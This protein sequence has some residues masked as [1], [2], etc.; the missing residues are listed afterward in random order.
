MPRT[1]ALF[2]AI[3]RG[4]A[5]EALE[6]CFEEADDDLEEKKFCCLL[7]RHVKINPEEAPETLK[8]ALSSC[9]FILER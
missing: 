9:P 2:T 3:N 4:K 5:L 1:D 8:Q 7:A 6:I